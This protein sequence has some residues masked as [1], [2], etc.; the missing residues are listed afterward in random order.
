MLMDANEVLSDIHVRLF[1]FRYSGLFY[2]FA[3]RIFRRLFWEFCL[4]N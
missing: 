3:A 2:P 4:L 1:F